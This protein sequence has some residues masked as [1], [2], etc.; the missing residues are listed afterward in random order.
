MM[1]K[2][3]HARE[4]GAVTFWCNARVEQVRRISLGLV[5]KKEGGIVVYY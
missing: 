4:K 5:F 1:T 3:G 2:L